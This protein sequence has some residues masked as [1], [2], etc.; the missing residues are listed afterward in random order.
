MIAGYT[1]IDGLGVRRSGAPA[2]YTLW[3]FLLTGIE[4]LLW[5]SIRRRREFLAY[6]HGRWLAGARPVAPARWGR[7][8][9]RYGR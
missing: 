7:T 4:M 3:I 8:C 5:I 6:L 1:V 2:A 9:L